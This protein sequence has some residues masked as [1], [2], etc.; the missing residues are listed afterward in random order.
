MQI[1]DM[2]VSEYNVISFMLFEDGQYYY[3]AITD[4]IEG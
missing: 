4:W 1:I 3:H 2:N